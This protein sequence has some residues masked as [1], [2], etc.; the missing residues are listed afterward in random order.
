MAK[1]LTG[2]SAVLIRDLTPTATT[3]PLSQRDRTRLCTQL[4][5][6]HSFLVLQNGYATEVV[7]VE[8][9]AAGSAVLIERGDTP[10]SVPENACVRF[11]VTQEL[12][13]DYETQ[14]PPQAICSIEGEG[15][16]TVTQEG[17]AVT[18]TLG[19]GC[20]SAS[21]RVGNTVYT[22]ANG[23]VTTE[24]TPTCILQPGTYR[25]ATI[26]VNDDGTICA[27]EEGSNIVYS[28]TP[29]CGCDNG[30]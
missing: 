17:C 1:F 14:A 5:G 28:Q 8:C 21:W 10:I 19:G 20:D 6:D 4:A 25:N 22:Y 18:L 11:E 2:F 13:D 16:I 9:D 30:G 27:I 26:R 23:C 12:L 7:R 24:T 29:C 3:L 15:G